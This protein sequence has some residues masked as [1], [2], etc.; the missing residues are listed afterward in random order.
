MLINFKSFATKTKINGQ[1]QSHIQNKFYDYT[2]QFLL[3]KSMAFMFSK[4]LQCAFLHHIAIQGLSLNTQTK[5][6]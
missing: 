5:S 3:W 4:S 6:L 2:T 1:F